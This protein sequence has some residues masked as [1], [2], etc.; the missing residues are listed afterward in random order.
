MDG[1]LA[2]VIWFIR[3]IVWIVA[4]IVTYNYIGVD[5][6]WNAVVWLFMWSIVTTSLSWILTFIV[7]GI[8]SSFK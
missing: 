4:G 3:G 7:L 5:S 2:I 8:L 6:F 1:I